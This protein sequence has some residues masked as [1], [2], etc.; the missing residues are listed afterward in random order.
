MI[1]LL[2]FMKGAI[3]GIVVR[4]LPPGRHVVPALPHALMLEIEVR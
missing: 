4:V 1:V 3:A 2:L